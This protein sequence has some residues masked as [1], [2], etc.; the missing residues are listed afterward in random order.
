MQ[1]DGGLRLLV[2]RG[3]AECRLIVVCPR[4]EDW[5]IRRAEASG[6]R[7]QD[8]DLPGHPHRLPGIPHYG[9]PHYEDRRS[10]H[11]FLAYLVARDADGMG[12]LRQWVHEGR[13]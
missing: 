12:L 3:N 1:A 13:Q 5:L 4:L 2:R 10:F 7:L 11:E 6:I 8:Y 9:I